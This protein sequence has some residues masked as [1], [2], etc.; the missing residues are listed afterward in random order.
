MDKI[1]CKDCKYC[2]VSNMYKYDYYCSHMHSH[3]VH[4]DFFGKYIAYKKCED[5]NINNDCKN[6]DNKRTIKGIIKNMFSKKERKIDISGLGFTKDGQVID[7]TDACFLDASKK[8]KKDVH[9][10]FSKYD[11]MVMSDAVLDMV[12]QDF[13]E[14]VKGKE[15]N[16]VGK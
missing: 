13:K 7:I 1:F 9:N 8:V 5:I 14:H 12:L 4:Y 15:T 3:I 2:D 11:G 10:I 16:N 6:F